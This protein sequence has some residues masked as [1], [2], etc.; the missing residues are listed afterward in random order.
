VD[1]VFTLR[2]IGTVVTG[3][4]SGGFAT[5]PN[6]RNSTLRKDGSHPDASIAWPG[7]RTLRPQHTGLLNLSD[8]AGQ[9][10]DGSLIEA[11]DVITLPELGGASETLDVLLK[12]PLAC[13]ASNTPQ[14]VLSKTEPSFAFIMERRSR[15]ALL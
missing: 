8:A 1:R 3:T 11:R 4:L 10:N 9:S 13:A 2:G 6:G 15:H 7:N 14:L 5:R 12:N